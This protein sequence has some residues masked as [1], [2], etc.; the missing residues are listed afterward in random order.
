MQL[1]RPT[2]IRRLNLDKVKGAAVVEIDAIP[3]SVREVRL[4]IPSDVIVLLSF[5]ARP[6]DIANGAQAYEW[7]E[8]EG[9]QTN[10]V[11]HVRG[12]Q[13][14]WGLLSP[15][16]PEGLAPRCSVVISYPAGPTP[17]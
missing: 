12:D 8:L 14:L 1:L 5:T 10:F 16:S 6:A 13:E 2:E 9:P 3:T 4:T 11:I 15:S 7:A 17:E